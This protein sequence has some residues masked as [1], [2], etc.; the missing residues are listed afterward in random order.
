MRQSEIFFG[1]GTA[2]NIWSEFDKMHEG[3]EL[4]PSKMHQIWMN[5]QSVN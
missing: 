4:D 5:I 1:H 2:V 3:V